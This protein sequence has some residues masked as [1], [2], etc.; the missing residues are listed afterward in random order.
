VVQPVDTSKASNRIASLQPSLV[1]RAP[2]HNA[3]HFGKWCRCAHSGSWCTGSRGLTYRNVRSCGNRCLVARPL[4]P[5][6]VSVDTLLDTPHN[7]FVIVTE[8]NYLRSDGADY[9]RLSRY[10]ESEGVVPYFAQRLYHR[11]ESHRM[12]LATCSYRRHA[13][14]Q[15]LL[16][17]LI[18]ESRTR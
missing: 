4:K 11:G 2:R 10:G 7:L 8:S 17:T 13:R 15:N 3:V 6:K 12:S 9:T 1:C 14:K 18:I 16:A 5:G